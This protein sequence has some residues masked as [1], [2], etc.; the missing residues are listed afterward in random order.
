M[1]YENILREDRAGI[2]FVTV[3]RPDKLNALNNA[4]IGELQHCFDA[5]AA[6]E[7]VRG[8]ILTGAGPKA[9]VAGADIGELATQTPLQAR[10]LALRGQKL[11]SSI[12]ACPKPVIAAVNGFAFG[13]GCELAL[14]CHIRLAS[15]N[16]VMGL[17]EVTLG[18]IPGYGG[19]QRLPRIVG[20]GRALELI[21]TAARVDAQEAL[22]IG[23]VNKV[24]PQAELMSQAEA[25]LRKTLS[26]APVAVTFA[27]DAVHHG[28]DMPL[29]DGLN[30]EATF[31]G[32]LAA[33]EDLKEGMAAFLQKRPAKFTGK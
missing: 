13:G 12:E 4:T 11:M 6:D 20:K 21:L 16:A 22:R 10:P 28:A 23:L 9:F 8:V 24:F 15:D 5:L 30:Y 19:T 27:L 26:F 18:I 32:L 29:A 17:P 2:A 31:F 1:A 14:A 3:N 7:S 25:M 33:T